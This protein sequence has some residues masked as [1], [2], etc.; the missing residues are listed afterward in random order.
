MR[1]RQRISRNHGKKSKQ[2]SHGNWS[3]RRGERAQLECKPKHKTND[4]N[5]DK[6]R[7]AQLLHFTNNVRSAFFASATIWKWIANKQQQCHTHV[8]IPASTRI[9]TAREI[10]SKLKYLGERV[11]LVDTGT[12]AYLRQDDSL[13][14]PIFSSSTVINTQDQINWEHQN[15]DD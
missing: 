11:S 8:A 12:D 5:Q 7:Q 14:C 6:R 15:L 10:N 13:I 4:E 1:N 9:I 3:T 2:D